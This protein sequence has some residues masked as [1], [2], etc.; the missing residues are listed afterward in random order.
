MPSR[1]EATCREEHQL[2]KGEKSE[3]LEFITEI[4]S[5]VDY[6]KNIVL[7]IE[8]H[9]NQSERRLKVTSQN[10]SHKRQFEQ[11]VSNT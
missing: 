11:N 2:G 3:S 8:K 9:P 6:L 10:Q 7:Y 1:V 4:I 5:V